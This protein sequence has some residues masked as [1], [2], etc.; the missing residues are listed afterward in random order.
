MHFMEAIAVYSENRVKHTLCW[1]ECS[2]LF[3]ETGGT[4]VVPLCFK[5]LISIFPL[6]FF[7]L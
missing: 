1:L 2:F 6:Q 7:L 3:G 5:R 4:Y